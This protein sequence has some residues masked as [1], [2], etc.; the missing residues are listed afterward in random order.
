M[1]SD[2]EDTS[3]SQSHSISQSG[4]TIDF[5]FDIY[6]TTARMA[7]FMPGVSPLVNTPIVFISAIASISFKLKLFLEGSFRFYSFIFSLPMNASS[8]RQKSSEGST[9]SFVSTL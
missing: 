2:T 3:I 4:D 7:A 1:I 9:H 5:K 8:S 6:L